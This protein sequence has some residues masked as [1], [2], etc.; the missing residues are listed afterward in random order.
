MEA[1]IHVG[2]PESSG[3]L[4]LHRRPL[5]R[6]IAVLWNGPVEVESGRCVLLLPL[7]FSSFFSFC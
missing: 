7:F 4:D 6:G 3:A 5:G 1:G 2:D